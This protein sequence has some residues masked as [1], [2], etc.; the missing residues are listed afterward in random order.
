MFLLAHLSDPHLA[1][2]PRPQLRQ[3]ASKR[4][5]GYLNWHRKRGAIH[6]A[7]I[8]ARIVADVRIQSP[9]HVAVIGDLINIS[10]PKEFTAARTWLKRLG[11]PHDVTLVPGNHDVYVHAALGEPERQWGDFMRGDGDLHPQFPFVRRRDSIALVGL[12]TAL[13]TPPFMATGALG[14]AQLGRLGEIL[15]QL[16]GENVFRIVLIHHP[17]Q[18]LSRDRRKR[19]VDDDA[20]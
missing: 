20:F 15:A 13:P 18:T 5:T 19:L 7:D 10:L 4:L 6:R 11:S 14:A 9:D 17:P 1:P 2:L 8:L 3:L 16:A 12:T